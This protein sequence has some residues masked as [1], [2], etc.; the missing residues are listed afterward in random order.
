MQCIH[1]Y[2]YVFINMNIYLCLESAMTAHAVLE[3]EK[4]MAVSVSRL[5]RETEQAR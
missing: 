3:A 5:V 2:V 1:M 4:W